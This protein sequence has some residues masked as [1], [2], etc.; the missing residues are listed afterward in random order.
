MRVFLLHIANRMLPSLAQL[1]QGLMPL[2]NQSTLHLYS[3]VHQDSI[4]DWLY[5]LENALRHAQV[6]ILLI[7]PAFMLSEFMP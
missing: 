4:E 3:D 7:S 1:K 6:A 2:E 5:S